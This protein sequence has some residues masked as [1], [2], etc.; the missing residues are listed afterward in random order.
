MD[1]FVVPPDVGRIPSK[2]LTGFSGFTADQFKNWFILFSIPSL[3][4]ILTG[5]HMACWHDFV[6]AC[7]ILCK[8]SLTIADINLS[9]ALL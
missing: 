9:D 3:F 7:R 8:H 5:E 2:I 4:G 6:L 1:S